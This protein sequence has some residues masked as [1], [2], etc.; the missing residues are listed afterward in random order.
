MISIEFHARPGSLIPVWWMG[1]SIE[2]CTIMQ[3]GL[4][5]RKKYQDLLLCHH[6]ITPELHFVGALG[7]DTWAMLYG[8]IALP[9]CCQ[10]I[11][12]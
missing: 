7:G 2:L 11:P 1:P 12:A 4:C 5:S 3:F 6:V 10:W 8:A 9:F